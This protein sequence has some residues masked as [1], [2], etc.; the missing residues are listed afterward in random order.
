MAQTMSE[1]IQRYLSG[2]AGRVMLALLLSA[3]PAMAAQGPQQNIRVSEISRMSWG[4]VAIPAT[5]EKY[6]EISPVNQMMHG[7]ATM[8]YGA[9]SRGAYKLS[10]TGDQGQQRREA[11]T[12]DIADVSTG[13]SS[14]KLDNF[15]G[16]YSSM[17][18]EHFP[19]PT[20]PLPARAPGGTSLYLGARATVNSA[21]QPGAY[22]PTFDID[23]IVN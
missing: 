7:N 14:L 22:A 4:M 23:V 1:F 21:V 19:S 18:I 17:M 5:G 9:P 15:R 11:I 3:V 16:M 10:S 2:G 13:S 12:I 6:I 20:L 8:M